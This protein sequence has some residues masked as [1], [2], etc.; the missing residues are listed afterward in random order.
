[1]E[2]SL[3]GVYWEKGGDSSCWAAAFGQPGAGHMTASHPGAGPYC[4][5]VEGEDRWHWDQLLGGIGGLGRKQR[6]IGP[7]PLRRNSTS[8]TLQGQGASLMS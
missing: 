1:M 2:P 4:P 3:H 7:H 6:V 8:G 5:N